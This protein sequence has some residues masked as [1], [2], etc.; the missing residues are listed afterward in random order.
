MTQADIQYLADICR[1]AGA[2]IL[3]VYDTGFEVRKKSD[4]SPVTEADLA[5]HRVI[6]SRLSERWPDIPALSEESA[7]EA[8]YEMRRAWNS[9]WLVDPLDGTK[10]FVKRNGQ[11][12]VNIALIQEG[13]AAAGMVYAPATGVLYHGIVGEGAFKVEP[14]SEPKRLPLPSNCPADTLRIV[15]SLSHQSP[16]MLAHLAKQKLRY[17]HVEFVPMGSSLKICLVAEG[18]AGEY[19]RY[20]PT[21]EW[22]TAAAHA[23]AKAAGRQVTAMDSGEE[24]R[25]NK[26]DLHNPW[27]VVR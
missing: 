23:V 5:A 17:R 16:R 1:E 25:Y 15:G 9:F 3:E 19:P 7:D 27:F 8:R 24:L 14:D 13:R 10:E 6:C 4:A 26:P 12:T 20:G 11:F 21:M 2:A 22:D 18:A